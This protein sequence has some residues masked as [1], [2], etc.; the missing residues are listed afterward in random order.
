MFC[1]RF[2]NREIH[3]SV[4][5]EHLITSRT[6]TLYERIV[7]PRVA[8]NLGGSED[9]LVC[10]HSSALLPQTPYPWRRSRHGLTDDCDIDGNA[11]MAVTVSHN[12]V[13]L[14]ACGV[15]ESSGLCNGSS[16]INSESNHFRQRQRGTS[17]AL[18][19]VACRPDGHVPLCAF[20]AFLDLKTAP[21]SS[22]LQ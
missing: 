1:S 14:P 18:L 6:E 15:S 4:V 19:Q 21:H 17:W 8:E 7:R 9:F 20:S 5:G 13:P 16:W 22:T 11:L 3:T 2:N 12:S 10:T